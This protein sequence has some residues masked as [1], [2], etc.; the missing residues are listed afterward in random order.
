MSDRLA[1]IILES[2]FLTTFIVLSLFIIFGK[3]GVFA[4]V[5]ANKTRDLVMFLVSA[6]IVLT[7]F[8]ARVWGVVFVSG[9]EKFVNFVS[10]N[11]FPVIAVVFLTLLIIH[12]WRD[13]RSLLSS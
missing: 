1:V 5:L 6:Q 4:R 13:I 3:R 12:L 9:F 2:F 10:A 7:A 11:I 8:M